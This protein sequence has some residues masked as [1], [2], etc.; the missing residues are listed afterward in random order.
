MD[1]HRSRWLTTGGWI[2]AVL[3]AGLIV[4]S[5]GPLHLIYPL[6]FLII[7]S[8]LSKLNKGIAEFDDSSGRTAKQVFANGGVG[9]LCCAFA[10]ILL[11]TE[12]EILFILSFSIALSDTSSS[13]LGRYF[14]GVTYDLL[15][16]KK[17]T[18]GLSGGVS[19]LGTIGGLWGAS[20]LPI[21]G[22]LTGM[23]DIKTGITL[24]VI[25]F[26]GM[27]LD[28]ILGSTIQGKYK[29]DGTIRETGDKSQ[30]VRGFH[31][32]DNNLV[33]FISIFITTLVYSII[34]L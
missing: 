19:F 27:I 26:L 2:T 10:L 17:V 1:N 18:P 7:G 6:T 21:L 25:S 13:E 8:L 5:F 33:N 3:L 28:S 20:I 24:S 16:M 23:V 14:K 31:P 9:M 29:Y 4:L 12:L 32:I 22:Y 11:M 15:S 30:L 34:I